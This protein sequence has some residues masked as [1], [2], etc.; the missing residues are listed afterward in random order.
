MKANKV[1]L[2]VRQEFDASDGREKMPGGRPRRQ[3]PKSALDEIRDGASIRA[4][5][6]KYDLPASV[7]CD[8]CRQNG[9]RSKHAPVAARAKTVF[10]R[11]ETDSVDVANQNAACEE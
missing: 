5:A 4:T 8:H 7:L 1:E 10:P 2:W 3:I 11:T 9:A 6:R